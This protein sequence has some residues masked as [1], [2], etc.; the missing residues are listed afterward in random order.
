MN[1]A[2]PMAATARDAH[3]APHLLEVR[4]LARRGVLVLLLGLLPVAAWL[5]LA[6]LDSAV[7]APAHVK[8][9]LDRVPVQHLEGGSVS[10]VKVRDGQQVRMGDPLLVLSDMRVQ[11]DVNRL[12]LRVLAERAGIA[13]LEAEQAG[14]V[15][16]VFAPELVAAA[17]ADGRLAAQLAKEQALF[18]ARRETVQAQVQLLRAQREKIAQEHLHLRGQVA[19]AQDSLRHPIDELR[20]NRELVAEGF[21]AETRIS[22]L[23]STIADYRVKLEERQAEAARAEQRM[24]DTELRIES[25]RGEYRQQASDQLK[26]A[27]TRLAE[28]EQELRKAGDASQRQ[29]VTA[30][31]SG[32]V[33]NLRFPSPGAVI[34]PREP[35][36]DI[37][38]AQPRL[39]VEAQIQPEDIERVRHGQ[40]AHVRFTAFH[41]LT[42]PLVDGRV[43]YLA[44]D[45]SL[46]PQSGQP[47]YV[48]QV[49]A[50]PD[51]LE[52]AGALKLQAGMPAEVFVPGDR[53]TA[54]AYLA[55]PVTLLLQRAGRER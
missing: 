44:A 51:S 23:E 4:R 14:A 43:V 19:Q 39:V 29:V 41:P 48:L 17:K 2:M 45:R 26:V 24:V 34:P 33:L 36:A 32:T 38:P 37:V 15:A 50:D 11:A 6:P 28:I 16:L 53:R 1:I 46:D 40:A 10:E 9:D 22:Q 42:T 54:L 13:R 52:R 35:I 27:N 3:L 7:V 20:R 5:A 18:R 12:G 31:A 30:P 25:L 49:E 55:E 21:I 47:Y 8:V